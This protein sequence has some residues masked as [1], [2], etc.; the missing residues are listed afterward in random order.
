MKT[1]QLY[2]CR[3]SPWE[4]HVSKCVVALA[5]LFFWLGIPK[6]H[7]VQFNSNTATTITSSS[8]DFTVLAVSYA[9]KLVVN[10]TSVQVDMSSSTG[11][12]FTLNS[13]ST[14]LSVS[15][16]TGSGG[17]YTHTCSSDRIANVVITQNAASSTWIITPASSRCVYYPLPTGVGYAVLPQPPAT[18]SSVVQAISTPILPPTPQESTK[19]LNIQ[20]QIAALLSQVQK[21]QTQLAA[22]GVSTVPLFKRDLKVGSRGDDV[23]ALQERLAAQGYLEVAPT[24]YFGALTKAALQ[25]YQKAKGI[26]PAAGYFGPKTRAS[27]E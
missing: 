13:T 19:K 15:T 26:S 23:R 27:M 11:G 3:L 16:S 25:K 10:A 7:A 2:S 18:T 14:D 8:V 21:L 5:I 24:G 6:T 4:Y 20:E 1:K 17:S 12:T 9:D 22:Q